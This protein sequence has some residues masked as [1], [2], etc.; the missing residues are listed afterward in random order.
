MDGEKNGEKNELE[1]LA[2]EVKQ[3]INDN[4][5]FLDRIMDDDFEPEDDGEGEEE[6]GVIEEL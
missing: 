4:R 5:K 2:R 6:A 3:L 1:D